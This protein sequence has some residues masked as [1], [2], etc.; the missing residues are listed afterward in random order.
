MMTV[1]PCVSSISPLSLLNGVSLSN[2]HFWLVLLWT[3][4][5]EP[6]SV[7]SLSFDIPELWNMGLE[8]G[9]CMLHVDI[10]LLLS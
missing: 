5:F 10:T 9:V 7:L 1:P 3:E 8:D 6:D 4:V 2:P